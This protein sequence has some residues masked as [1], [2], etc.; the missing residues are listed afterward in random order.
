MTALMLSER[1]TDRLRDIIEDARRI[2]T[3]ID[4]MTLDDFLASE[5]TLFAVE[6]LLQR[7]TEA[8]IQIDPSDAAVLGR[9]LPI[10][11]MRGLG[12]RLRHEYRDLDRAVVFE[13]ARI[14]VPAL[15]VAADMAIESGLT[16]GD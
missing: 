13:I 3:F 6:R 4:G 15:A 14:D 11:K 7:I 2:E 5:K 10:D 9:D 8:A 16:D 12:N 1:T